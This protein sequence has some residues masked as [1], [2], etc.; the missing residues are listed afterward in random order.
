M[1]TSS[2]VTS[3]AA[4]RHAPAA[5]HEHPA[6]HHDA[7]TAPLAA[8]EERAQPP[9]SMKTLSFAALAAAFPDDGVHHVA[10]ELGGTVASLLDAPD[11]PPGT[12][13]AILLSRAF[14]VAGAQ[15]HVATFTG[16]P[17]VDSAGAA[18]ITTP[19][20]WSS[21]LDATYGPAK[22]VRERL[23]L[24]QKTGIVLFRCPAGDRIALWAHN[25]PIGSA[26]ASLEFSDAR[27][28]V[29]IWKMDG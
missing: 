25:A 19:H 4:P 16:Q 24:A 20:A 15:I 14:H 8:L 21:L 6:K 3:S 22:H 5:P 2:D 17:A 18:Y 23:E 13:D 7:R 26:A 11:T 9:A 28:G 10:R 1:Q 29:Y 27:S 12:V